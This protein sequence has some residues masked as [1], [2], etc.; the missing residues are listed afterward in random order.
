[1]ESRESI[2]FDLSRYLSMVKRQWI[3]AASIFASTVALSVVATTLLKPS[4]EAEGKLLFKTPTFNV[5][6]SELLPSESQARGDLRP[7]VSTQN[8]ITTQ[9]EVI[10]SPLLLQKTIDELQLKNKEGKPLT[11]EVL[12]KALNIKIIG[13]TDVLLVSYQSPNPQEAAAVVNNVMNLYLENDI[14]TNRAEAEATRKFMAKQL[15]NNRSAVQDAEAALRIFKQKYNIVDLAEETRSAVAIIG[16]LD[17][18]INGVKADFD[19]ATA[20]TNELR[21]KVNLNSQEALSASAVSQSPA[22]QG[23]LTQLQD[24]DR[25]L[26]SERSRFLDDNP[27]I[28]NL[29]QRKTNL[30]A[31][32]KQEIGQTGAGP[33]NYPPKTLQIGETKQNLIRDFLQSEV[34]RR[35]LEQKLTSLYNSRSVYEQRVRIIP[36]LEQQQRDL[37]RRLEV[38]QSTYQTLLKKVQELQL[39]ENNNTPNARIIAKGSVPIKPTLGLKPFIL[40]LGVLLGAFL[41]TTAVIFLETRD[42]SLK[43]LKEIREIFGY[44]LLGIVPSSTKKIRSRYRETE[45]ATQEIA[46][47]DSPSSLTSEIYRMIQA[48]LRFLSSDKVLKTIVVSSAVPKEGKS[49]VSAN[50]AAAIAQLGRKV[51]LIDADM[52]VPTQH[53]LWQ[54]TNTAGLSE[55]L[56]G[57]AEFKTAASN[58]IENLDVLTAGVRPPNPLALLDSKRMAT[59]IQEFSNQYDFVIIDAPP[60]LLAADAVTLSHMTDGILLVARPGVIDS[61]SANNAKELLQRSGQNVLGLLVNG[62]NEKNESSNDFYHAKEYFSADTVTTESGAGV[63]TWSQ[64]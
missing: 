9:I 43:T 30:Q 16:N 7:L 50:L 62:I 48:N 46:V 34:Q 18:N 20:Q 33:V 58:V 42:R 53:H 60:L 38:A 35:G 15:P 32:L 22:V 55:V 19:Q 51:L 17:S 63:R 31:L 23:I 40:V 21:Q 45:I 27:V 39:A 57:E 6:G 37:E 4:Y 26:A 14:L 3:P 28:I 52:R 25:Q 10:T 61:N 64:R 59:L 24:I 13:G 49:T 29:E 2:D 8:P 11:P 47:I 12:K 1:M 5:V 36:Q 56:V 41:A 44:T 54:I